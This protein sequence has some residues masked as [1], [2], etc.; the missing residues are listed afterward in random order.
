M[1]LI[2][3]ISFG[4]A[5]SQ[6]VH[7]VVILRHLLPHDLKISRLLALV[8]TFFAA[9]GQAVPLSFDPVELVERLELL[10]DIAG[11]LLEIHE[12]SWS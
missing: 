2:L 9:I 6:S 1:Q 8:V 3:F 10:A 5:P 4:P 12:T 11:L 7:I